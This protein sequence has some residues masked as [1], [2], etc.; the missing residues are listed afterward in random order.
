[1]TDL[2][3]IRA[4]LR[5]AGIRCAG[6]TEGDGYVIRVVAGYF[7]FYTVFTFNREGGLVSIAAFEE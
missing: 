2:E 1:V 4:M 7:G 5:R 3:N 6:Q